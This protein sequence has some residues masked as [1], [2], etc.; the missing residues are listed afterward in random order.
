MYLVHFDG[1]EFEDKIGAWGDET[2]PYGRMSFPTDYKIQ[3]TALD[4]DEDCYIWKNGG[5]GDSYTTDRGFTHQLNV[6]CSA[7]NINIAKPGVAVWALSNS[8]D[9]LKDSY[10]NSEDLLFLWFQGQVSGDLTMELYE[11]NSGGAFVTDE[12]SALSLNTDYYVTVDVQT[13]VGAYGTLRA[14]IYSDSDRTTL[15]DTLTI[16]LQKDYGFQ[17][18]GASGYNY[19][20]TGGSEITCF[21][22]NYTFDP[23]DYCNHKPKNSDYPLKKYL[24]DITG[25][26]QKVTPEECKTTI[27][28]VKVELLDVNDEIT[29]LLATDTTAYFHRKKVKIKA[30]YVGMAE[31]DMLTIMN[32]GRITEYFEKKPGV[33]VFAVTDPQKEL[34]RDIFRGAEDSAI[35]VS[36]NAMNILLGILTSSGSAGT[37]GDYDYYP[38]AYGL[39]LTTDDVAVSEIEAVRD[40]WLPGPSAYMQ[41]SVDDRERARDWLEKEILKPFN[42]RFAINGEGKITVR[43]FKPPLAT[44]AAVQ[45]FDEDNIVGSP[46]WHGNLGSLINEVEIKHNWDGSDFLSTNF[47]V[48]ATS[49]TSRGPGKKRLKIESKGWKT[50]PSGSINDYATLAMEYRKNQIWSRWA[51]PP[52][53][54]TLSCFFSRWL[55]EAGDIVSITHSDLP[56][57]EAGTRGLTLTRMEIIDRSVDWSRGRVKITLLDTGFAQN[58]YMVISPAA[59]VTGSSGSTSFTVATTDAKIW[60]GYTNPVV[61][62]VTYPQGRMLTSKLTIS[63]ISTASGIVTHATSYSHSTGNYVCFA[64]YNDCTTEQARYGFAATSSSTSLGTSSDPPKLIAP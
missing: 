61:K 6:N 4:R 57:I 43:P 48:N 35:R 31:A 34:D 38:T 2:D 56:D 54:I 58:D 49:Q 51:T 33:Y 59:Q 3:F 12:S 25:L 5:A 19:D 22:T 21:A 53:K 40:D 18:V 26:D 62:V 14:R 44:S 46:K 11:T 45:S 27:G 10:T 55:S 50:N 15:V 60:S 29:A 9:D 7:F 63:S 32:R 1:V 13:S 52:I 36:G 17:Y 64:D 23:V 42:L 30:G 37:N 28:G 47:Y 39:D 20:G 24:V 8:D 16:A 41:F